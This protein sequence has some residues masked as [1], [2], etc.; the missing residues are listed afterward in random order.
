MRMNYMGPLA[1]VLIQHGK[2]R[3]PTLLKVDTI[4]IVKKTPDR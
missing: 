4:F 2:A 3:L 1:P